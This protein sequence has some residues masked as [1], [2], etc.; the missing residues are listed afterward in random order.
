M[1][2]MTGY[3]KGI[4]TRDG[5]TITV[6][7]KSVNHR[8]LDTS[9]KLPRG[10]QGEEDTLKKCLTAKI[11]RGHVDVFLT[12]EKTGEASV[13]MDKQLAKKYYD[14]GVQLEEMGIKNDLTASTILRL[15]DVLTTVDS[16]DDDVKTLLVKEAASIAVDNLLF[17]RKTEGD[18][19][20]KD[21]RTKIDTLVSLRERALTIAPTVKEHYYEVLKKRV[22]DLLKGVE[23]DE[24][25]L[26]NEVAVYSDKVAVDEELVRLDGH[27]KHFVDLLETGTGKSLDFLTQEMGREVNTLGSKSN[28]LALTEIVLLMKNE[29]EKI[30]EQVQNLE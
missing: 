4:A 23:V 13:A 17:M 12:Y 25:R 7:M 29:V 24:G 8:F 30:R 26:L 22:G 6:E 27:L 1:Y 9:F 18:A 11:K 10:F 5:L 3:G 19:L 21:L 16:D 20:V 14:M 15:P 2:S 28:D